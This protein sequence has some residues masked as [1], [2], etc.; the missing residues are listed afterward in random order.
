MPG[1]SPGMTATVGAAMVEAIGGARTRAARR[2]A[3][4][5]EITKSERKRAPRKGFVPQALMV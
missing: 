3:P 2:P 5:G 4:E 1:S